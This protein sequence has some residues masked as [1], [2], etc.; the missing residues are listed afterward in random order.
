M[1]KKLNQEKADSMSFYEYKFKNQI[2]NSLYIYCLNYMLNLLEKKLG[3]VWIRNQKALLY[4]I[5]FL[6]KNNIILIL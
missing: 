1:P 6:D 2:E 3:N 4:I 5:F